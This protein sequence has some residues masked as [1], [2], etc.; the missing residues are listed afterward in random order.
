MLI[1]ASLKVLHENIPHRHNMTYGASEHKEMEHRVH[2]LA[3][4]KRIEYGSRDVA[5]SLGY[6]PNHRSCTDA[7]Q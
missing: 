7:R 6:N 5:D 2:I 3:A 1:A 4:V